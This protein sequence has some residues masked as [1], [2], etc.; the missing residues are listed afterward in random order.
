MNGKSGR[1]HSLAGCP[2]KAGPG[3]WFEHSSG[4]LLDGKGGE[5][6]CEVCFR[7]ELNL[8]QEAVFF[9]HTL[10]CDETHFLHALKYALKFPTEMFPIIGVEYNHEDSGLEA[11]YF[12]RLEEFV[13]GGGQGRGAGLDDFKRRPNCSSCQTK[14]G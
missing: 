5:L 10:R 4:I 7:R 2:P 14:T 1:S 9:R 3:S 6:C 13:G 8:N 12:V 11:S